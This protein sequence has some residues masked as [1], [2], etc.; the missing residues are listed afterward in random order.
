MF[1]LEA[2]DGV[3]IVTEVLVGSK[4]HLLCHPSQFILRIPEEGVQHQAVLQVVSADLARFGQVL[5][6]G[7]V[8]RKS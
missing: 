3:E 6:S 8:E 5:V 4:W 7:S 2:E 1:L